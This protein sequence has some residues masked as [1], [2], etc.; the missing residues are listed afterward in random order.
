M[1]APSTPAAN[2]AP[3]RRFWMS[4][5]VSVRSSIHRRILRWGL[6]DTI[7]VEVFLR[8]QQELPRNLPQLLQRTTRP[9][10]G[11]TY[12]FSLVDPENRLCEHRFWFHLV[13]T[14]DEQTLLVV[15]CAHRR[16]SL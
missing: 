16:H 5:R 6:S 4:Y 15:N 1:P 3:S 8:L 2:A 7:L 11:M 10:D 14:Q 12:R 13:F 9:F